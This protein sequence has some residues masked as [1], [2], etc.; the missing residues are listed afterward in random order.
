M[1]R[2]GELA[3]ATGGI[4][5][6][7]DVGVAAA[8]WTGLGAAAEFAVTAAIRDPGQLLD[9]DVNQLTAPAGLDPADHPP[10]GTVHP[11]Q[12]VHAVT[13]QDPMHRRGRHPHDPAEAG[14]AQ[15]AGLAQRHDPTLDV[16]RG[17]MRTRP[18]T[19]RAVLE[20]PRPSS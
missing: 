6:G 10:G 2:A 11:S 16:G 8:S 17:L 13:D 7:V 12:P 20:P 3:D 5:G 19:T 4:D 14:W 1:P 15:F 18:R 9:V